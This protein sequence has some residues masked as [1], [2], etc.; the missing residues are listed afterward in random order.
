MGSA[1]RLAG[2]RQ[3][4]ACP[5]PE[6]R[7]RPYPRRILPHEAPRQQ[8]LSQSL[9]KKRLDSG[10]GAEHS[11][12]VRIHWGIGGA[13]DAII[14]KADF[15][16]A[17]EIIRQRPGRSKGAPQEYPLKG[18]LKCGNCHRTL[19]RIHSSAGYYYY[20]CTKSVTDEASDCPKGKL[21][22]EKEIE[23]IV[24]R[25]IMQMLAVCQERNVELQEKKDKT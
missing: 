22:S 15:D 7:G 16:R 19:S 1:G 4:R 14:S 23:G 17:Q 3:Y 24:F 21:F 20:R 9:R 6:Q 18:L 13:H 2:N 8:P 5:P 25:A 10:I 11:P 12:S